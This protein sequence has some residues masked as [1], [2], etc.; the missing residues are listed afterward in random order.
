MPP[1]DTDNRGSAASPSR[2]YHGWIILVV[3]ML[4]VF[5]SSP[6]QTYV[7]SVFVGPIQ[8]ETGWSRTLISALYTL[9]S[10]TA[11]SG[12]LMVGRLMDRFGARATLA[13]AGLG[14]AALWMSR[15]DGPFD[16]YLGFA[17]L[18]LLGQG[19]LT[20][21][22]TAM[23]AVWFVRLRGRALALTSL[24]AIAGQAVFPPLVHLLVIRTDWRT[25]WVV[26]AVAVW[27]LL[28]PATLLFVRRSPEA[29]GLFPDGDA[30]WDG[31][32]EGPGPAP[33]RRDEEWTLGEALR[34][35]AFWLVV[36]A[37]ASQSLITTALTFHHVSFMNTLGIDSATA[38]TVFTVMAPSSLVGTFVAGTLLDRVAGHRLLPV[39]PACLIAAMLWSM[40]IVG[41]WHAFA[42]GGLLGFTSGFGAILQSVIWPSYFGRRQIGS[43]RSA[44]A[45]G[46]MAAAAI[47]PLP[48]GWMFDVTASARTTVRVFLIVP[49]VSALAGLVAHPPRR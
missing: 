28:L 8:L 30:P 31:P 25:A 23:V 2:L 40:A 17:L 18:R 26:L 24:G 48:F 16:L 46:M 14:L 47:G 49:I 13:G 20:V 39:A 1:N 10:L 27:A 33:A 22:P 11:A 4:A 15:V 36:V 38:A 12:I 34:T 35:R 45:I 3:A 37:V 19:A 43:I 9:G 32:A 42:Y 44:G 7:V 29:M 41:P 6:G 21:V 5:A